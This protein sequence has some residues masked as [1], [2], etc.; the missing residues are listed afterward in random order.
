MKPPE[1]NGI[2]LGKMPSDWR[3]SRI[4]NVADLSPGYSGSVPSG[5]EPCTVVPMD[6]LSADGLIDITNQQPAADVSSGLTLFEKG[7]VL[8][9]KITPCMENGKG[10]FVR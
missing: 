4:R 1:S 8:F 3:R 9:A 2:W 7:D 5:D 6:S 10:A